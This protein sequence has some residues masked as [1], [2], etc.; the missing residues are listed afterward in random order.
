MQ[1]IQFFSLSRPIQERFIEAARAQGAPIPIL[2]ARPPAPVEVLGWAA[3]SAASLL[4]W[5]LFLRVGYGDLSS[6]LAIAPIWTVGVQVVLLLVALLTGLRAR[7]AWER[8]R[9]LPYLPTVY[10]FPVGVIDARTPSFV[11]H[12]LNDMVHVEPGS[13]GVK[14][15]FKSGFTFEFPLPA[16]RREEALALVESNRQKLATLT[17]EQREKELVLLDPLRDNGFRNPFSPMDSL[18]PQSNRGWYREPLLALAVAGAISASVFFVRNHLSE[19]R[20]YTV[21][22]GEDTTAAYRDYLAR[23]GVRSDVPQVLLPRAELREA[24]RKNS[25]EAI[26]R[27]MAENP[28]SKIAGEVQTAL[29]AALLKQLEDAKRVGTLSALSEFQ[30]R[31]GKHGLVDR[32]VSDARLAHLTRVLKEFEQKST[33]DAE[34]VDFVRRLIN[35]GAKK[36]PRVVVRFRRRLPATLEDSQKLIIKSNYFAGEATLPS[37]FFG[38]AQFK[39]REERYGKEIVERLQQL[40]PVELV[41]FELDETLEDPGEDL[42][43]VEVP[44]LLVTYRHELSGAYMSRKPRAVFAGVGIFVK[45]HFILPADDKPMAFKYTGWHAPDIKRLEAGE[46][47]VGKV[48]DDL[49]DKAMRKFMKKYYATWFKE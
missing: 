12:P 31:Y 47:E 23:G 43:K 48:Y 20:L 24:A 35:W 45:T 6:P 28:N 9:S 17:D 15:R 34:L 32:E 4:A 26:E 11:V 46:L 14:F 19:A 27:F 42:P 33:G 10:L 1:T 37:K 5:V 13:R 30:T 49:T 7:K 3:G 22:R 8:R 18:R 39:E 38:P 41:K 44:T 21:A 36:G 2:V 40:L 16:N 25:V 29:K